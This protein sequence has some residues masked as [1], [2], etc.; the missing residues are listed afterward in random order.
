MHKYDN[1]CNMK[2]DIK[3]EKEIQ[4]FLSMQRAQDRIENDWFI[5]V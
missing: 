2:D 1:I 4:Y 5:R 3:W